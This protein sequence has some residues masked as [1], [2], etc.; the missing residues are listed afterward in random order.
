[1][2]FGFWSLYGTLKGFIH[3]DLNK[4]FFLTMTDS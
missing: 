4:G 2:V 1:M 3:V